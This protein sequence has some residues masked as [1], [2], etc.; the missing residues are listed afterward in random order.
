M[1]QENDHPLTAAEVREEVKATMIKQH[2]EMLD[3]ANRNAME[4]LWKER[5]RNAP[6]L[7]EAIDGEVQV[8][9]V[10][11]NYI[12]NTD[13]NKSNFNVLQQWSNFG[14]DRSV[15]WMSCKCQTIKGYSRKAHWI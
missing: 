14:R 7:L 5:A 9:K 2:A 13:I 15:M 11:D 4:L 12:W 1:E 3:I 6:S 10:H 8:A